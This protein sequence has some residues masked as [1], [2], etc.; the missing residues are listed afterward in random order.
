MRQS[1]MTIAFAAVFFTAGCSSSPDIKRAT[2]ECRA[3][4]GQCI[5]FYSFS[6]GMLTPPIDVPDQVDIVY[7]FDKNDCFQGALLGNDDRPGY[8]FPVGHKSWRELETL[9]PPSQDEKSVAGIDLTKDKEE[10]AF[11]VK[12]K[13]P[14]YIL[15]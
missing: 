12:A 10:L 2:L 3:I 14:E 5:S 6:S 9:S 11:W 4:E 8:L 13:G 7:Y 1:C 15:V